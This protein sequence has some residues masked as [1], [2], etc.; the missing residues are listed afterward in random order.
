MESAV[1]Q[2]RRKEKRARITTGSARAKLQG[3]STR[4]RK[5][6]Q[7]VA[8]TM[9]T[10]KSGMADN[11]SRLSPSAHA[12]VHFQETSIF[13]ER[14]TLDT[15]GLEAVEAI[16]TPSKSFSPKTLLGLVKR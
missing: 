16:Q 3:L 13:R 9:G 7:K 6:A 12:T 10:L 1:E 8:G 4:I 11:M 15:E 5:G 14:A 2:A